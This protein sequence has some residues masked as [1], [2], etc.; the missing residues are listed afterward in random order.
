M[1]ELHAWQQNWYPA[2]QLWSDH[3]Q[4]QE[5]LWLFDVEETRSA[6]LTDNIAAIRLT[7]QRV[8]VNLPMVEERGLA[9]YALEI[10]AH[11]IGHHVYAPAN[12]TRH[13][14]LLGVIRRA[15][16]S[17]EPQAPLVANLYTDLLIN[18]RLQRQTRC[19]MDQ[20]YQRLSTGSGSPIWALYMRIYERLWQLAPGTLTPADISPEMDGDAWLGSRIIK[21]YSK[22]WLTGASRFASLLLSYL[23]DEAE[24][25]QA[26]F[27]PLEDTA[28]A[29]QGYQGTG[30]IDLPSIDNVHPSRD[31][32]LTDL[33]DSTDPETPAAGNTQPARTGGQALEPQ[34]AFDILKA[35][36]VDLTRH[37]SAVRY[38]RDAVCPYLLPFPA[39]PMPTPGET[40]REGLETWQ[41]GDDPADID[42][43]ATLLAGNPPIP[44]FTTQKAVYGQDS[45]DTRHDQ[46]CDLDLYV[47]S[48]ASMP[49]PQQQISYPALAGALLCVSA[50]RA[51]AAVQVT[52]WSGAHQCL[53]TEGFIRNETEALRVL[54]GFFGGMTSFPLKQLRTTYAQ[55]RKTPTQVV[56]LSDDG[57]SSLFED[58][59][60][61][62]PG[63]QISALTLNHCQGAGHWVLDLPY[64]LDSPQLQRSAWMKSAVERIQQGQ[65]QGWQ[66]H[67]VDG[68]APMLQFAREFSSQYYGAGAASTGGQ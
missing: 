37:E 53:A 25:V 40:L 14:Q 12:M 22:D 59:E 44:G 29:G 21:V 10:L 24:S 33:P 43:F 45:P 20:L 57:I 23:I 17:M 35:A 31:T 61:G 38:Y 28:D 4:L 7:S 55:P 26:T 27:A 67:R 46:P 49:N 63:E 68:L 16:P 11:E 2:L 18:H 64:D 54:T 13:L 9:D 66:V 48:S 65:Q 58:D 8:M 39:R 15:L 50:L 3:L 32:E 6:G 30:V 60:A 62:T 47:D 51:G 36:G 42:W 34:D 56:V 1:N 5:P 52:L 41:A 19:R